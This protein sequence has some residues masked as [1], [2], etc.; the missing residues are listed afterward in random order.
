MNTFIE[1]L[2]LYYPIHLYMASII[3]KRK[4]NKDYYYIAESARVNGKP[5]IVSQIYLGTID[6]IREMEAGHKIKPER[7]S[8]LEFGSTA[9]IYSILD[10]I[11]LINS[12]NRHVDSKG[13]LT[14]GDYILITAISRAVHPVSHRRLP[15]W[16]SHSFMKIIYPSCKNMLSG[17]NFWNNTHGV[18]DEKM[19]AMQREI[20]HSIMDIADLKELFFDTTNFPTFID[21]YAYGGEIAKKTH[22]KV[23]RNDLMH[24]AIWLLVDS[25]GIPLLHG[26]YEANKGDVE[27]FHDF[28]DY[29]KNYKEFTGS[30]EDITVIMGKG[31]NSDGNINGMKYHYIGALRPSTQKELLKIPMSEY[32]KL[33]DG[34]M[35]YRTTTNVYGKE[36]AIVITYNPALASRKDK[37]FTGKIEKCKTHINDY[38]ADANKSKRKRNIE[39]MRKAIDTY[40]K[41]KKMNRYIDYTIDGNG[42]FSVTITEKKDLV[43]FMFGKNVLFTDR[44][45]METSSII[46]HYK[47]RWIIEDGFRKMNYDDNISVTPIFTWTDQQISLHIFVCVI[48][49][50]ALRILRLKLKNSGMDMTGERALEILRNVHAVG[51]LYENRKLE[52]SLSEMDQDAEQ[53]M[54][55][56]KLKLF[57]HKMVGNT[58]KPA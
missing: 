58:K 36:H 34:T 46:E 10:E 11:G 33:D 35:Y 57:F 48:A 43:D 39:R 28:L 53:L 27:I 40:L 41:E 15:E 2:I 7:F 4:G 55:I 9:A 50:L 30:I 49:L 17:Q 20:L 32:S 38:I 44:L 13:K 51:T 6:R 14:I 22:S 12:V 25:Q 5:R 18:T 37:A 16:Y 23:H 8:I 54:D 31:N 47:D 21:Q 56:L 26:T 3:S 52:W 42:T 24:I 19:D 29:V 1:T 45:D